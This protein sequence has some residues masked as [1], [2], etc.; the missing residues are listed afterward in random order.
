M[1]HSHG[2]KLIKGLGAGVDRVDR[3]LTNSG[4]TANGEAS[5]W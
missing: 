3:W 5:G 1:K 2:L 4:T